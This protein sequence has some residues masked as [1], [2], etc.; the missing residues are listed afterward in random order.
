MEKGTGRSCV[1]KGKWEARTLAEHSN[2]D[3][4]QG[5]G[6]QQLQPLKNEWKLHFPFHKQLLLEL[7]ALLE[8][9]SFQRHWLLHAKEI[10]SPQLLAP[11]WVLGSGVSP[12]L[13]GAGKGGCSLIGHGAGK[14]TWTVTCLLLSPIRGSLEV[15]VLHWVSLQPLCTG[16]FWSPF[17]FFNPPL[18]NC[19]HA[20]DVM[21]S[22]Y[23]STRAR[24][25]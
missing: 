11:N 13:T 12:S 5:E 21:P 18:Q 3:G 6:C 17:L 7:T 22:I 20:I 16:P 4:L 23:M 1:I 25:V 19:T 10:A 15:A 14:C 9:L 24:V 8:T 2:M